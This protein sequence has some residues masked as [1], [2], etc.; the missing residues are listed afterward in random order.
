ME[1][2]IYQRKQSTELSYGAGMWTQHISLPLLICEG[3]LSLKPHRCSVARLPTGGGPWL[4]VHPPHG[5]VAFLAALTD[6]PVSSNH[7]IKH[8]GRSRR[9]GLLQKGT[10]LS[11]GAWMP[12]LNVY[13]V[14]NYEHRYE[15]F[16]CHS[17]VLSAPSS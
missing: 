14:N 6:A 4:C 2:K 5:G 15:V 3:E 1:A 17:I 11:R 16:H 7:A 9:L 8:A 12:V 10:H 13:R